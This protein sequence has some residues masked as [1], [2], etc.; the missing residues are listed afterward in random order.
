MASTAPMTP[1]IPRSMSVRHMFMASWVQMK[2]CTIRV[3]DRATGSTGCSREEM[4][5]RATQI[6]VHQ[7]KVPAP[8]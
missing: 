4:G 7:R 2:P 6:K 5:I 3:R 1:Q 8:E